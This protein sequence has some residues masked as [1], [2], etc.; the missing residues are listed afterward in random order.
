MDW[1][2]FVTENTEFEPEI[3]EGGCGRMG[4]ALAEETIGEEEASVNFVV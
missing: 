3:W 2:G 1:F 4:T